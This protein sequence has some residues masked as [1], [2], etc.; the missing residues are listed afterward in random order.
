[1]KPGKAGEIL[2]LGSSAPFNAPRASARR[3]QRSPDRQASIERRRRMVGTIAMPPA[4]AAKFTW[5][6]VAVLRV[7]GK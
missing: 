5:G 4:L 3:P 6:E 2:S 1:L 7:V